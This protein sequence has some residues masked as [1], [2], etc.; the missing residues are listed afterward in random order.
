MTTTSRQLIGGWAHWIARLWSLPVITGVF[1]LAAGPF[2]R[3]PAHVGNLLMPLSSPFA[4]L[5]AVAFVIAWR[6]EAVGGCIALVSAAALTVWFTIRSGRLE[7]RP[8]DL[9]FWAPA[10]L[11]VLSSSLHG[12]IGNTPAQEPDTGGQPVPRPGRFFALPRTGLGWWSLLTGTGFFVFMRLFWMQ[13]NNPG[14]DRSTFFSDPIN[15]ACLIGAFG[16]PIVAMIMALV[17]IIWKRERS[18]SLIPLLLLGLFA[19]LW[20]LAVMSGANA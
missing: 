4:L 6:W 20:A 16:T 8:F 17:A 9:G 1:V 7:L 11:F 18:M 10:I 12:A 19:L 5:L 14:R 3:V 13:A 2:I 15:A